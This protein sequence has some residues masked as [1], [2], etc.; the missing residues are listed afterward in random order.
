MI[1]LPCNPD[2]ISIGY[3]QRQ[4]RCQV[5]RITR[6]IPKHKLLAVAPR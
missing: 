1:P 6:F 5:T 2:A 3:G 4:G